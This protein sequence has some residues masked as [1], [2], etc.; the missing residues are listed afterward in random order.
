MAI[1][2]AMGHPLGWVLLRRTEEVPFPNF[3]TIVPKNVIG[4]R[5]MKIN[6]WHDEKT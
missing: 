2:L 6:V 3:Y 5:D 1:T 4:S